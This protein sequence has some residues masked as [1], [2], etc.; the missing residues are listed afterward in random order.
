MSLT[1]DKE[2]LLQTL[3]IKASELERAQ[4]AQNQLEDLQSALKAS[5]QKE[6]EFQNQYRIEQDMLLQQISKLESNR[7]DRRE[8]LAEL[9]AAPPVVVDDIIASDTCLQLRVDEL[10]KRCEQLQEQ[11]S[12]S[13]LE[14]EITVSSKTTETDELKQLLEMAQ[15][16]EAEL[17]QELEKHR[18]RSATLEAQAIQLAQTQ[19]SELEQ[20]SAIVLELQG[21]LATLQ[22]SLEDEQ[23]LRFEAENQV[24]SLEQDVLQLRESALSQDDSAALRENLRLEL[25][26]CQALL[27]EREAEIETVQQKMQREME[28]KMQQSLELESALAAVQEHAKESI[29]FESTL[30]AMQETLDESLSSVEA[31]KELERK[32]NDAVDELEVARR[33]YVV[34]GCALF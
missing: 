10:E 6:S 24:Q 31:A 32:L 20:A 1:K 11:L 5:Q 3:Q 7:K 25:E 33:K 14:A 30:A 21:S 12:A 15:S 18:Q 4:A 9:K 16:T 23:R 26:R 2:D 29:E 27:K 34:W 13:Q 8:E 17:M 22:E 28:S 19:H